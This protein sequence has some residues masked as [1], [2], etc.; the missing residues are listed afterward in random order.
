MRTRIKVPVRAHIH[1]H[2]RAMNRLAIPLLVCALEI[3]LFHVMVEGEEC[4]VHLSAHDGWLSI[5]EGKDGCGEA[6]IWRV[7]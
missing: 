3:E 4:D 1:L 5:A 7:P 6:L 2:N